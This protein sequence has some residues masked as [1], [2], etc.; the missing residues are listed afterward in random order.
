M[1][2]TFQYHELTAPTASRRIISTL[3]LRRRQRLL[4]RQQ[5][6]ALPAIYLRPPILLPQEQ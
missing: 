2:F 4:H 5:R 6:V 3:V 1:C